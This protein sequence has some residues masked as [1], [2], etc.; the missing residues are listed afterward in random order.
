MTDIQFKA[1]AIAMEWLRD[2]K[3]LSSMPVTRTT[4]GPTVESYVRIYRE[5]YAKA[6]KELEKDSNR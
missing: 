5:A 6:L 1:H 3:S 2:H 4:I